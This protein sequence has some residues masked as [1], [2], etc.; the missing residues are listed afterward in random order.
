MDRFGR[1]KII[2]IKAILSLVLLVPLIPFG[3]MAGDRSKINT[4]LAFYFGAIV[5]STFSNDLML[6][7]FE[8]LPKDQRDNYIV[9]VASTR[10]IGIGIVCLIFYFGNK[11][12]YFIIVEFVLLALLIPLYLKYVHE[13]PLQVMVATVDQD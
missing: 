11:W 12:V 3:L 7:G 1:K 10:I 4:V 8:K 5:C 13:S 9:I 2:A 6:F